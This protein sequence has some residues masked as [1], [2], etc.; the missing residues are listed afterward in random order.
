M[1]ISR[2]TFRDSR[3][4]RTLFR[5]FALGVLAGLALALVAA[6]KPPDLFRLGF[7]SSMLAGV[8]DND[9]RASLRALSSVVSRERGIK[10]DPEPVLLSG[11]DA[12]AEALVSAEVDAVATT[13]DE[14]WASAGRVRFDRFLMGTHNGDPAERYVL[15]VRR[16]TGFA[17]P[18]ALRGHSL[19]LH[20]A[21]RMRLG[22]LWLEVVLARADAL[23][24]TD[25]FSRLDRT[26]KLSKAV[27]DVFFK[28]IDACLVTQRAFAAVAEM[29]P[30][31]GK[32]LAPIATS[33]DLVPSFFGFRSGMD[34]AF[35]E[36]VVRELGSVHHTPAG[37]QA[38][39]IFQV[40]D[41]GEF[42][43]EALAPALALLDEYR[44]RRPDEAARLIASLRTS[45]AGP[46][47]EAVP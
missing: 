17:E 38:I 9:A 2:A 44:A 35:L 7:C 22:Y 47:A 28:R 29:N 8:N 16:D 24:V 14:Y 33:P 43:A 46:L 20:S 30:Q 40:G 5:R 23:P 41:L 18:T 31:V 36:K 3:A 21:P 42:G 12:L 45:G 4:E 25:F 34:P 39:T 1:T 32:E 27:L 19:A 26:P 6:A 11:A 37:K 13:V 10:A 15:L